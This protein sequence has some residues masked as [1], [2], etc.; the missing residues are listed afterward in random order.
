MTSIPLGLLDAIEPFFILEIEMLFFS[1]SATERKFIEKG[2]QEAMNPRFIDVHTHI[3]FSAFKDDGDEVIKRT[4]EKGV[5]MILVGSQASTSKRAVEY[6]QKHP[7][8]VYAIVGLHPIHTQE[9]NIDPD[10]EEASVGVKPFKTAAEIFD[11]EFYKNLIGSSK[12]IVGIGECGLDYAW[13]GKEQGARSKQQEAFEAQIEFALEFGLPVMVHC[14]NADD[15]LISILK[16]YKGRFGER[17]RG[18]IHFFSSDW[19]HAKEYLDLGLY[20]SFPGVVTFVHDR[21]ETIK[22]MPLDRI[23]VETDAP[24]VAPHPY[25]GKRNE[26]LYVEETAKR[27]SEI[28]SISFEEVAEATTTNAR[29]LFGI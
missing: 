17:L 9:M 13:L 5:W 7:E 27:I 1:Q 10:E 20:L 19:E 21:D 24:Y 26:P 12:K 6:A 25:R 16:K 3:N 2:K 4:L 22:N 23:L 28:R 18:D 15:D 11:S 8:G 14:R 29:K